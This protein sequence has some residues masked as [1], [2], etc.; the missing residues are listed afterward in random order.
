[1]L[2]NLGRITDQLLDVRAGPVGAGLQQAVAVLKCP[3][4]DVT[5]LPCAAHDVTGPHQHVGPTDAGAGDEH[6]VAQGGCLP[7]E[8]GRSGVASAGVHHADLF[9]QRP[10]GSR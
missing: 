6:L 8:L 1:V 4:V 5:D 3:H 10:Q 2:Q 7:L 9:L